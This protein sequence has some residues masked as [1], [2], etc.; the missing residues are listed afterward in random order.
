MLLYFQIAPLIAN[1]FPGFVDTTYNYNIKCLKILVN[2]G[3]ISNVQDYDNTI[4][5]N[6]LY[7]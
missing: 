2:K 4:N 1:T 3:T 7:L 6:K 5:Q